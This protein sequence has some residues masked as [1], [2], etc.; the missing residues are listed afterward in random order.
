MRTPPFTQDIF[1]RRHFGEV[2]AAFSDWLPPLDE[3]RW[4]LAMI[5]LVEA[6]LA[7]AYQQAAE[8]GV[9]LTVEMVR[10]WLVLDRM[11]KHLAEGSCDERTEP[12]VRRYLKALYPEINLEDL[13]AD[14]PI[15]YYEKHAF[16]CNEFCWVTKN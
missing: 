13:S 16:L 2:I 8:Q 1:V 15:K 6:S 14:I 10:D 11:I 3:F 12:R 4:R 7:M 5:R 9:M